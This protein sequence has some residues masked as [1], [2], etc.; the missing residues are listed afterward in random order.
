MAVPLKVLVVD[1]SATARQM[2]VYLI[3]ST[4]D[5]SVIGEAANGKQAVQLACKL[6]PDVILMDLVMP[7]MD[8]LEATREIMDLSPAPIVMMSAS[9]ETNEANIAF[10]AIRM[11]AL[12]A[13]QKPRGPHHPD[14]TTQVRTFLNTVRAMASVKVIHHWQRQDIPAS[15]KP[16]EFKIVAPRLVAIAASTGGPAAL[17]EITQNLPADFMLPIVIVQHIAS[18]F[19]FSL[20][21]WLSG[22]TP[23]KIE[24]AQKGKTPLPGHIYLAP[25]DAHL[26]LTTAQSFDLD[27]EQHGELHMPSGNVL[28]ASVARSYGAHAIGVVL[29]GMGSDGAHG[30]QAMH[31]AGAFTIAQNEATSV[32]YGMPRE[33]VELGAVR[34]ILPVQAIAR[35]LIA[36]TAIGT[37]DERILACPEVS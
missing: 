35:T 12:M 24:I 4:S 28:L 37:R 36:L 33:A 30:L 32:V 10:Q 20:R 6:H 16:I 3:G 14:H 22:I 7:D 31:E 21:D 18:D 17:A 13:V 34:Q 5:M 23:L 29:T 1:D 9:L 11:G 27:L 15:S 25:G 2:L 26:S 19:V 8:G